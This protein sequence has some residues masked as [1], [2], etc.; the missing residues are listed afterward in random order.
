MKK[1]IIIGICGSCAAHKVGILVEVL[2]LK[3]DVH[4]VMTND[5]CQF[6]TPRTMEILSKNDVMLES[7]KLIDHNPNHVV[8]ASECELC[9]VVPATANTISKYACGIADNML[10]TILS[11]ID[12]NKVV[13]APAMNEKMYNNFIIADNIN[14]LSVLGV[15]IIK[16]QVGLQASGDVGVGNLADICDIISIIESRIEG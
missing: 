7:F 10:T 5:A 8:I 11:A 14:Q 2:S 13:I 16:P 15:E 4:V 1:K 9:V 12:Y 6:V 3:Y